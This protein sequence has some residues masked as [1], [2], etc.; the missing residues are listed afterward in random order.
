MDR[1]LFDAANAAKARTH[2]LHGEP[3]NLALFE[4]GCNP[5][6]FCC[7]PPLFHLGFSVPVIYWSTYL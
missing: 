2:W 5:V 4:G 6:Q 7:V 1:G 3:G